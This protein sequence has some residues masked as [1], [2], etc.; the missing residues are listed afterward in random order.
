MGGFPKFIPIESFDLAE[1]D[2]DQ[3]SHV[4]IFNL[5]GLFPS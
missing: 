2:M 5:Y 3:K 1:E 4:N